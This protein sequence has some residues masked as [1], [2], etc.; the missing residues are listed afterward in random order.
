MGRLAMDF[1]RRVE[2]VKAYDH[3]P[4][5]GG[6]HGVTIE[7][8]LQG[9]D[10]AVVFKVFTHWHL[11]AAQRRIDL[12]NFRDV[13][14][15]QVYGQGSNG[16]AS[17]HPMSGGLGYHSHKPLYEG[18]QPDRDSCDYIGGVCYSDG[19]L[20]G[21]DPILERL[22]REGDAGVWEE[23]EEYYGHMFQENGK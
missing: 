2:F 19:S 10:G 14:Y 12:I 17:Y 6:C 4:E 9:R 18:E 16:L 20:T 5:G 15:G 8:I 7:F 1:T 3:V 21:G 11:P 13:L 23:L 22:I